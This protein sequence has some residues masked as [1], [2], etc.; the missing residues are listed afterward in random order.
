[1]Q[2]AYPAPPLPRLAAPRCKPFASTLKPIR[3]PTPI[4]YA[5][6]PPSNKQ[7]KQT[8]DEEDTLSMAD[9][10]AAAARPDIFGSALD[11][12]LC[13]VTYSEDETD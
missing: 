1:M 7:N 8:Y 5:P 12:V 4:S 13:R 3:K 11:E 2:L 6:D 10:A 9:A